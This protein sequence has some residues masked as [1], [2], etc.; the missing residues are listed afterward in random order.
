MTSIV[1]L[2][3]CQVAYGYLFVSFRF[4]LSL[5][6]LAWIFN[7]YVFVATFSILLLRILMSIDSW[8]LVLTPTY[9]TSIMHKL[10]W[11]A[12]HFQ[13]DILMLQFVK[14]RFNFCGIVPLHIFIIELLCFVLVVLFFSFFY[15]I[16]IYKHNLILRFFKRLFNFRSYHLVNCKLALRPRQSLPQISSN[17]GTGKL[18]LWHI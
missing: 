13:L 3:C 9:L 5:F 4:F 12:T 16:Y 2:L 11:C 17:V 15:Y 6:F 1:C 7:I 8:I 10:Q 14:R 18:W